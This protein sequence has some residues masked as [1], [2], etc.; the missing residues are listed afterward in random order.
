MAN[1]ARNIRLYRLTQSERYQNP[2]CPGFSDLSRRQGYYF[3]AKDEDETLEI[4][5][6]R[7]HLR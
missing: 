3:W 7:F 2:H 5:R 6:E 4:M 1:E